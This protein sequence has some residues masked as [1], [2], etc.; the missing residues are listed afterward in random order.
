[1]TAKVLRAD[2]PRVSPPS[3]E[4]AQ[5]ARPAITGG[6]MFRG[7]A[8]E[9]LPA[10]LPRRPWQELTRCPHEDLADPRRIHVDCLGHV[11]LCQGL[12]MGNFRQAPFADLV[13]A[14]QGREHP[15]V[16]PLLDGGPAELVRRYE[17]PHESSYV[18]ECH[19]CFHARRALICR[20]PQYL[21]PPQVYGL[22]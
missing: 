4:P 9:K 19:L 11:H 8:A 16:G 18:D 13:R 2:R 21:A 15:I 5:D 17:L 12:S 1:M 22:D 7:R 6:V 14:Y 3:G 20:F 10:D